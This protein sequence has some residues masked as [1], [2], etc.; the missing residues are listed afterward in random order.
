MASKTSNPAT[1]ADAG[2]AR[3]YIAVAASVPESNQARSNFQPISVADDAVVADLT[4]RRIAWMIARH[5]VAEPMARVLADLAF[6]TVEA[7]Q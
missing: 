2:R 5:G 4:A 1:R 7:R 3:E 6:T